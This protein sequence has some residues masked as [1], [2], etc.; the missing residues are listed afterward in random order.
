[1]KKIFIFFCSAFLIFTSAFSFGQQAPGIEW[2]H[3]FGGIDDDHAYTL[4]QT[5]DGGYI[6]GGYSYSNISG[7]KTENS[8]GINDY[9]IIKTDIAGNIQWQK[10]IGGNGSDLLYFL[11]QTNDGGYILAGW[12][13][14]GTAGDKTENCIGIVDYWIV[15]TDSLGNIQ[16]QNT[17][18][19]TDHD[20]LYYI[21]QTN[22]GGYILGGY[23]SSGISGDHTENCYGQYDYWMIKTDTV[24]N[25]QWQNTMGGTPQ[26]FLYC[27]QQTNDGGY[28]LG[29]YSN[30][31]ISGDKTE[32]CLGG[33]D[34]WMVKTDSLGNIQWQNDIG[35][36]DDDKLFSIQQ[37]TDGGYI[38]GGW[39]RSN[40]SGDKTENCLGL[41]DY[42]IVKTDSAGNIQWQNTIGGNN[43][44]KLNSIQQTVDGG[45]I[46]GGFSSSDISGDKSESSNGNVD[47]WIV[48]TDATGN[49]LWENTIG[50]N[51]IDALYAVQQTSDGGYIMGGYSNSNI[52]GDK[53]EN[54]FDN[55]QFTSDYW[56]VKLYP[57]TTTGISN[58][59]FENYDLKVFPNPAKDEITI[60]GY[61]LQNN[62]P[63][64]LKI[65]DAMGKEVFTQSIINRTSQIV[66]LK[67]FTN[68]VYFVQLQT[69]AKV[70]GVKFAKE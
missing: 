6:L 2:Q 15:K 5:T 60:A 48:K 40:I 30:S 54:N 37:T 67:S 43:Y 68:G 4:Q 64:V 69:G 19:G 10:T 28:I 53:T 42:W 36:S 62:Q 58:V 49:I 22:D 65:Y 63:A 50:G 44:D 70:S 47:Y 16:W 23:T 35:G 59:R 21:K 9:W 66:N 29:G 25:I 20:E 34:Y 57:D 33:Y 24:G 39:S 38:L 14:S 45:Y 18:G 1:M 8:K 27:V 61:T 11:Q 51:A 26:D 17:I 56:I 12:S 55:T 7:N 32:N 13:N 52:S 3:T 41:D 31:L 46:L